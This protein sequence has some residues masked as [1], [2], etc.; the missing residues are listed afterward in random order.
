MMN[1]IPNAG[2][3]AWFPQPLSP[4]E[5]LL[6]SQ[7]S[8]EGLFAALE[9][10]WLD[11]TAL[12]ATGPEP[13]RETPAL[14]AW[15]LAQQRSRM[16][17]SA[18]QKAGVSWPASPKERWPDLQARVVSGW[19]S[20]EGSITE[21]ALAWCISHIP[22][23]GLPCW[24]SGHGEDNRP[25]PPHHLLGIAVQFGW[26]SVVDQLIRRADCPDLST[27]KAPAESAD[28][29]AVGHSRENIAMPLVANAI[30]SRR[31]GLAQQ[32]LEAGASPNAT[33]R[34]GVPA[35]FRAQ[36]T[37]SV[38]LLLQH[39]ADPGLRLPS[40]ETPLVWWT[41]ALGS[42]QAAQPLQEVLDNWRQAHLDPEA[43]RHQRLS[44]LAALARHGGVGAFKKSLKTSGLRGDT[45][46][47]EG[48]VTWT[49][50]RVA[51]EE[52]LLK[53]PNS[54]V[55]SQA[56][57]FI[58]KNAKVWGDPLVDGVDNAVFHSLLATYEEAAPTNA[59]L[60][61]LA[62]G[63][64]RWDPPAPKELGK[65]A[66]PMPLPRVCWALKAA[67]RAGGNRASR[68]EEHVAS[69][70]WAGALGYP[71]VFP[72]WVSTGVVNKALEQVALHQAEGNPEGAAA[73]LGAATH[74]VCIQPLNSDPQTQERL[75]ERLLESIDSQLAL[76][77]AIATPFQRNRI[78]QWAEQVEPEGVQGAFARVWESKALDSQWAHAPVAKAGPKPRM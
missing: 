23:G 19:G 49:L 43:E 14:A 68:F 27:L 28:S 39:G 69:L 44:E 22:M 64:M 32:L 67:H 24:R 62:L 37:Q 63:L 5:R 30:H 1:P 12:M 65:L 66:E 51:L 76:G 46:W 36:N 6:R 20:R 47:K 13:E 73:W 7:L 60:E 48:G 75:K 70:V 54:D 34:F 29:S 11:A 42:S 9:G 21:T 40:G 16:P 59:A 35:L 26:G 77:G 38:E 41:K 18:L 4:T 57:R 15:A 2:L 50:G 45:E 10:G 61:Q 55:T 72:Y 74:W 25:N 58:L 78:R 71:F 17:E 33:D 31:L 3:T 53:G 56:T 8:S 52:H